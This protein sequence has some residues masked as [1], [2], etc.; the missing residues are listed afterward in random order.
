MART[1]RRA[2][3]STAMTP[4]FMRPC[5]SAPA[6]RSRPGRRDCA[7]PSGR[8]RTEFRLMSVCDDHRAE[9]AD[10]DAVRLELAV[11]RLASNRRPRT[12][13]RSRRRATACRRARPSRRCSR[14]GRPGPAA[15]STRHEGLDAVD[16][17]PE[18]DAHRVLPVGVRRAR[19]RRRRARCRRCCRRRARRRSA[20]RRRRRARGPA[21]GRRRRCAR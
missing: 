18:V 6:P 17:A 1:T 19:D 5:T 3:S 11:E 8:L 10:A 7:A 13:T 2:T 4:P 15:S 20:R 9:H 14:C 16:D 12:S 21:P